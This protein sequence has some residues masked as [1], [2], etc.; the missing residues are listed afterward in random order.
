[1]TIYFDALA[2]QVKANTDLEASAILAFQGIADQ[3][4]ASANDPEKIMAL[5]AELHDSAAKLAAAIPASTP[6]A[7]P[8]PPAATPPAAS[9][10][11]AAGSPPAADVPS[12]TGEPNPPGAPPAA[13]L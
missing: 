7:T 6:A 12:G 8:P 3:I 4:K 1:M 10:P 2:A 13:P 9:E 5:T 11:P